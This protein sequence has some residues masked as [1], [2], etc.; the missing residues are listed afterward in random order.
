MSLLKDIIPFNH[1][2]AGVRTVSC[3]MCWCS[4]AFCIMVAREERL[5]Y[6]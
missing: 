2:S 3:G 4:N 5:F 6:Y 1:V